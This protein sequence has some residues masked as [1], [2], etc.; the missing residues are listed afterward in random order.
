M[1]FFGVG[2][3]ACY[4]GLDQVGEGTYGFVYKATDKRTKEVVALK[5]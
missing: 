4:G 3:L 5:R 1:S 2:N